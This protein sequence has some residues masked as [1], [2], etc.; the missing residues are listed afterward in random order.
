[1]QKNIKTIQDFTE[2]LFEK[3]DLS[4]ENRI[5]SN[6]I[7]QKYI[8]NI[9][10]S[11][12]SKQPDLLKKYLQI[13]YVVGGS[14][15][16]TTLEFGKLFFTPLIDSTYFDIEFYEIATNVITVNKD[17][18][19][20]GDFRLYVKDRYNALFNQFSKN[21]HKDR[22]EVSKIVERNH[23]FKSTTFSLIED[24]HKYCSMNTTTTFV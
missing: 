22:V 21:L 12:I 15:H 19:F 10:N 2:S 18:V 5:F 20:F 9:N 3:Y 17:H 16:S 11:Q 4:E 6:Y 13:L 7:D 24:A 14:F 23:I 8:I 1:L